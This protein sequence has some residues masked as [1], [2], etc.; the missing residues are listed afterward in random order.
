MKTIQI[1]IILYLICY[2]LSSGIFEA[3]KEKKKLK[4]F[5]KSIKNM[6]KI[7]HIKNSVKCIEEN[8]KEENDK[9]FIQKLTNSAI[10][11]YFKQKDLLMKKYDKYKKC[12]SKNTHYYP[13]GK[14]IKGYYY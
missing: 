14:F 4:D 1:Y 11:N 13:K 2:I 8:F 6:M 3:F 12:I 7:I 9:E 10:G 5:G